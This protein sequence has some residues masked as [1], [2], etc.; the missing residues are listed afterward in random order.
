MKG[1]DERTA[2]IWLAHGVEPADDRFG[3]MVRER[4]AVDTLARIRQG[5]SGLRDEPGIRARIEAVDPT[6]AQLQAESIGARILHRGGPGWPTQLDQLGDATPLALWVLGAAELRLTAVRSVAMVGARACTAYGESVARTWAAGLADASWTIVS[7]G[8]LGIDGAAHR[9]ALACGGMTICILACGV[10]V[11]YPRANEA[12]LH[13]IADDGLLVSESPLG[14]GVRRRRFL[15]RNRL[16]A[17]LTRATVVV[18]AGIRS[19][20]TSTANSAAALNRPVLAVPGPVTSAMSAGCHA[21]L[22]DGVAVLAG[23]PEDVLEVIEPMGAGSQVGRSERAQVPRRPVDG[24]TDRQL[25]VLDAL[26]ARGV[27]SMD[28]LVRDAGMASAEVI[29]CLAVLAA[30]GLVRPAVGGWEVAGRA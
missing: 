4:G 8:A 2:L 12:L 3:A 25:R 27:S 26:P 15:T 29:G 30:R 23:A 5:R 24:L 20:T 14:E 13:R 17:A 11:A 18:E 21:L 10:D 22:R 6:K 28:A 16:I 9:G 1:I 7:G 19:G